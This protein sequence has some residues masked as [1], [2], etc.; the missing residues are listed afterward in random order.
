MVICC[1]AMCQAKTPCEERR[2]GEEKNKGG[3]VTIFAKV[4]FNC[5]DNEQWDNTVMGKI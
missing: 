4:I 3:Q 5:Y 2:R 1:M